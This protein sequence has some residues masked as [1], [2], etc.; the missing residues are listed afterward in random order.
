[1]VSQIRLLSND[2][3]GSLSTALTGNQIGLNVQHLDQAVPQSQPTAVMTCYA[4]GT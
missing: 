4:F 2:E 3:S 1:M